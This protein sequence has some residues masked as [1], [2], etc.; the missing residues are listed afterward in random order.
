MCSSIP[1]NSITTANALI[2]SETQA[3]HVDRQTS[4]CVLVDRRQLS[5]TSFVMRST[6]HEIV[7]PIVIHADKARRLRGSTVYLRWRQHVG[8]WFQLR[9][10]CFT[11]QTGDN[12]QGKET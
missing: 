9:D 5:N 12:R 10:L 3:N 2:G 6:A 11:A 1:R 8:P 7:A 4:P